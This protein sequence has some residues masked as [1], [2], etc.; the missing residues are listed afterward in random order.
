MGKRIAGFSVAV[1]IAMAWAIVSA[2]YGIENQIVS[3]IVT[4]AMGLVVF[5]AIFSVGTNGKPL[6]RES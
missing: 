2:Q 5:L 3:A 4:V 1:V 6:F